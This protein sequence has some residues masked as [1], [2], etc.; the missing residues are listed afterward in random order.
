M[1]MIGHNGKKIWLGAF[2]DK[3]EAKAVYDAAAEELFG[4]FKR[5]GH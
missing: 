5:E 1:S 3:F 4:E 2:D